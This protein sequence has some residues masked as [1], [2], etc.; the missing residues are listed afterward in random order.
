MA[1]KEKCFFVSLKQSKEIHVQY[2]LKTWPQVTRMPFN[3]F[4]LSQRL[5]IRWSVLRKALSCCYLW[6]P[7]LEVDLDWL[8]AK[9]VKWDEMRGISTSATEGLWSVVTSEG[10]SCEARREHRAVCLCEIWSLNAISNWD[11][12][13]ALQLPFIME[14]YT[15]SRFFTHFMC[16]DHTSRWNKR[17]NGKFTW[18]KVENF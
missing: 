7:Y 12:L 2:V 9:S 5:N 8:T 16:Q 18:R 13:Q 6:L 1:L 17:T 4:W 10:L 15:F 3:S 14:V 11:L